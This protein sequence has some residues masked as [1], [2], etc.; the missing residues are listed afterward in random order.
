[1]KN[2][3]KIAW[4]AAILWM[5]VIFMLSHQPGSQSSQLSSSVTEVI[6]QAIETI[7]PDSGGG[8]EQFHT[9]VRKN[10]HFFAYLLL[11]I[12]LTNALRRSGVTGWQSFALA[13]MGSVVYAMS[14]EIHQLFIEGRSGEVRDVAIDSA[15]AAAGLLLYALLV[16]LL[17][18]RNNI[19]NGVFPGR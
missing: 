14:D 5:A 17:S 6:I 18:E 4:G 2:G 11:G 12:L 7:V 19:K 15:G 3:A 13:F 1:M 8:V 16:K 10:A 9:I